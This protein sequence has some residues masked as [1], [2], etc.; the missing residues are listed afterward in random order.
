MCLQGGCGCCVVN[1]STNDLRTFAVNSC[2]LSL[3]LCDG[4]E[5][6]TIEGIGSKKSGYHPLQKKL[7]TMN[8]SQCGYCSPGMIMNMYSLLKS[9]DANVTMKEVENSF[10]GN[11]C[12]CTGYRPILDAMKSFAVD[13][14]DIEDLGDFQMSSLKTHPRNAQL[15]L[16]TKDERKWFFP[17]TVEEVFDALEAVGGQ[18]FTFVVGNTSQ[19]VYKRSEEITCFIA[20]NSIEILHKH[21]VGDKLVLGANMS[22]SEVIELLNEVSSLEAFGYCGVLRDHFDLIANVPVRNVSSICVNIHF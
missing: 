6:K 9:K 20:L 4:W 5:I 21:D 12:R 1:V 14:I 19:G 10:S 2:L 8:A 3:A 11:I 15:S 16:K 13:A 22:L 7:A 18:L 17:K